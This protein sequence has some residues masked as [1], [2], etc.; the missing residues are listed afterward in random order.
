MD[1]QLNTLYVV[2]RGATLARDHLTVR[3]VVERTTRLTVPSGGLVLVSSVEAPAAADPDRSPGS[4]ERP[5]PQHALAASRA[6]RGRPLVVES[7]SGSSCRGQHVPEDSLSARRPHQEDHPR[8]R[9]RLRPRDWSM[10]NL[11]L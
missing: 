4:A 2:T 3:V 10:S 11:F 5:T 6:D 7:T 8:P 1:V 9:V